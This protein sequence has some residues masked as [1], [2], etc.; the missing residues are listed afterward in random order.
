MD[1]KDNI[2]QKSKI[3]ILLISAYQIIQESLKIL[4]EDSQDMVVAD[5]ISSDDE[6]SES[7]NLLDIDCVLI[8]LK[9]E[10]KETVEL[11]SQLLERAPHLRIVIVAGNDDHNSQMRALEL[12]AVGIVKKEQNTRMLIEAIR[13]TYR[14]E[15]WI[16]QVL[17][18]K[19]LK[20]KN[21]KPERSNDWNAA[22]TE[23]ITTREK[24]VV[25]M[26][27]KG[28]KN[29]QIAEKMFISEATVRHHLSS[30]YGKLGV[31]DRLNLV[32]YAYQNGLIELPDSE[33]DQTYP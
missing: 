28:L 31:D 9:D 24:Q 21:Q 29:K 17:L 13:Q 6:L 19:L 23:S 11:I 7:V 25:S 1:A 2:K 15:T 4:I 5:C 20:S 10:D 22:G 8:Y 3:R 33:N 27:G 16:N 26:I 18:A 12:G 30:I 14:G 32:I